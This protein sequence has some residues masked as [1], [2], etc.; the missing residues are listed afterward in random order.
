MKLEIQ[1]NIISNLKVTL[2]ETGQ[3]QV[4]CS[5]QLFLIK[6][7]KVIFYAYYSI[8]KYSILWWIM[9]SVMRNA[10]FKSIFAFMLPIKLT[11]LAIKIIDF[12]TV[13]FV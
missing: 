10:W 4:T 2:A 8:L 12:S 6:Y 9:Y 11:T 1:Q 5:G 13:G 7:I 3:N